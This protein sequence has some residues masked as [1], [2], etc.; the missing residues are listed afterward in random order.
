MASLYWL[1]AA[2]PGLLPTLW[3]SFGVGIPW[4]LAA[5]SPR[6][7]RS[8][9]QIGALALALGPALVTAWMLGLGIAGAQLQLRLLTPGWIALGSAVI[10]LTGAAIAWRKRHHLPAADPER[11]PLYFDEKLILTLIAAAVV[12]R[13]IHTAF[14]PFTAYDALWVFGYQGRLFFLEGVIPPAVDYYPP[15]LSLQFAYV[16]ILIGEINDHAAR[17]VLPLLHIGSILAAYLLGERL[18]GRRVG[19]YAAALWSLHPHVG[20]W[21]YVGDLEI[22]LTFSF[23]L[24]AVY[25]LRAWLEQEDE[26]ARRGDAIVAGLLL[27]IALFTKPTAG[28]FIWGVMLLLALD[29]ALRRFDLIRWLRRFRVALWTGLACLPLG[30]VWYL[31]NLALGHEAVTFPQAVWLTRALRSGDFL[32][33]LVVAVI[34]ATVAIALRQRPTRWIL[35]LGALGLALM[36]AGLLPSNPWLSPARVDPP[37]S[38]VQLSEAAA[39]LL[40]LALTG[41]CWRRM[42][43]SDSE[44]RP[45]R[46]ASAGLWSLC[47]ALPYF[48]TFF[49]SYSYHFR[50]GFAIVPLL[51]LPSAIALAQIFRAER[52]AAAPLW[53][54]RAYTMAAVLLAAPGL[55][56]VATHLTGSPIWLLEE[57]LDNDIKKYQAFNPS[58][59]E[60][61]FGLQDY[62]SE[63]G[64]EPILL[65]P[66]EE[67][68]PFFFPQMRI[69]DAP[70]TEL[71]ELEALGISH[72]LFGAKARQAY[73]EAGVNPLETQIVAALGRVDLFQTAREHYDGTIGYALYEAHDLSSRYQLPRHLAGNSISQ[74]HA[75]F[76]DSIQLWTHAVHPSRA[77]RDTP[78][79]FAPTWRT[80]APLTR[81]YVI[82]LRLHDTQSGTIEQIWQ[83]RPAGHRYGSYAS[84][85]WEP[86]EFIYDLHIVRFDEELD[87]TAGIEYVFTLG[88]LDPVAAEYLPLEV[89]G[90]SAG[91]FYQ[92]PGVYELRM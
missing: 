40:G 60:V 20:N 73:L 58:L 41:V 72:F 63:T 84:S 21:A 67:R 92:L 85:Y 34:L 87:T 36:L 7:W 91:E 3:M 5:L 48:V 10:A 35:A 53:L 50:L 15:F 14:W 26:A 4:A 30:G 13:W 68:L 6:H 25:F 18:L 17:M 2:L 27:G 69:M 61:A 1:E 55:V 66:G 49:F 64:L 70:L 57:K 82:E 9:A 51:C 42:A 37:A 22:P 62:R 78:L 90:A 24:A 29:L 74:P 45:G 77:F 65:A 46:M 28:A 8:R 52:M 39:I 12:L 86:H 88:I 11:P 83:L 23:T 32:A 19:I 16:Q 47:L 43:G 33:P 31:R 71:A 54:R 44:L 76:G 38:Y 89:D 75:V 81:A 80:L 59:M 56:A 79:T